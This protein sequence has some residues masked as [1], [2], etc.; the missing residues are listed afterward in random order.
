MGVV[1]REKCFRVAGM[2]NY[3]CLL[4][5]VGLASVAGAR[6]LNIK[7]G[8]SVSMKELEAAKAQAVEDKK[9]ITVI[10]SN[11]S[12]DSETQGAEMVV[13]VIEDTIK[14]LKKSSVVVKSSV[15]EIRS[16]QP[17]NDLNKAI[18][19]GLK[20]AGNSLPMIIVVNPSDNSV[21]QVIQPKDVAQGGSKA[22]RDVKK[23]AREMKKK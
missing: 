19:E 13:D 10:V 3:I 6:E 2:K 5:L 11:R 14:A 1:S 18:L 15:D 20:E 17:N 23:A 4:L 22:F 16:L 7:W 8:D 21:V 12:Y 9:L